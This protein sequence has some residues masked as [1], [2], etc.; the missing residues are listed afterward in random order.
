MMFWACKNA[1]PKASHIIIAP[2]KGQEDHWTDDGLFGKQAY[3]KML[4]EATTVE[5]RTQFIPDNYKMVSSLMHARNDAI[6][7]KADIIIGIASHQDI[8]CYNSKDGVAST[9]NRARRQ[10]KEVLVIYP[11][12]LETLKM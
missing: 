7:K 8:L 3:K 10:E 9:L 11:N 12:T 4:D 6:I 5:Y 1:Y 2:F